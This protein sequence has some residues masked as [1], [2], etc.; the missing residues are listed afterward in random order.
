MA[1]PSGDYTLSILEIRALEDIHAMVAFEESQRSRSNQ[2]TSEWH[3][4]RSK[5]FSDLRK[6]LEAE[7]GREIVTIGVKE[8]PDAEAKD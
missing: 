8:I 7:G 5:W 1:R 3:S 4:K 2:P 6:R